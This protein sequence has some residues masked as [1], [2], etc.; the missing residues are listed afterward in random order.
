MKNTFLL[1]SLGDFRGSFRS[2][3]PLVTTRRWRGVIHGSR[4]R[5]TEVNLEASAPGDG[6]AAELAVGPVELAAVTNELATTPITTVGPAELAAGPIP[7]IDV[8]DFLAKSC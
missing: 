2:H 5:D 4:P 6:C 8:A 1:S 7:A 3:D